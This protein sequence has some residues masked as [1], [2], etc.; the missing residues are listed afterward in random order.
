MMWC[1]I[2]TQRCGYI[3]YASGNDFTRVSTAAHVFFC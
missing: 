2:A 3:I 1:T